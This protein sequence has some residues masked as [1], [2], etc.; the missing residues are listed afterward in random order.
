MP[1][2]IFVIMPFVTANDR[3]EASLTKFF[4]DYIKGPVEEAHELRGKFEVTRSGN[5]F[6]ILDQIILD[7]ASADIVIC[8]LSGESANPNVIYELGIRLA[9]SH[10]PVIL[11][12]ENIQTNKRMFDVSGLYTYPYVL[13]DTK[14]LEKFLISKI[15][16]YE[17]EGEL[18][19]SPVL[20][21]LNHEAAFWM[22]LPIRKASAFLGG[23]SSA[24]DAHLHAFARAVTIFSN[25]HGISDLIVTDQVR[26]Y[27]N[28]RNL[29]DKT[30]LN[31]FDYNITSIPSLDSYLSSVYLL[32]LVEDDIEKKFREYAMAYSLHFNTNNSRVFWPDRFSEYY[33]F[34]LETLILMNLCRLIIQIL[35]IRPES[36][37]R[38]EY[39][40]KFN[41]D[42]KSS[43]LISKD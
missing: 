18:F 28:L 27:E 20:Q 2:K 30:K 11:I 37:K 26:V 32:G 1:K 16:S 31:E 6:Q 29:Q 14:A 41:S 36:P 42:L 38:L 43:S 40:E 5:S 25:S 13:S 8:D 17:I 34:A 10:K 22:Q 24:A 19:N 35:A 9:T 23:I 21:V 15:K 33:A 3:D 7:L 39:V 4:T 12:R